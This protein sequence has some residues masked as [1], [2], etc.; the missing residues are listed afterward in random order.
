MT[1]N[2]NLTEQN[3]QLFDRPFFQFSQLKKYDPDSIPQLKTDYKTAWLQWQA[4]ITD[5]YH[6]LLATNSLFSNPHIERWCNGWQVRAHFFAYFKYAKYQE[7][8]PILSILLN[9][10]RLT[11][12]L[13]W[14][15]YKAERSNIPL[16]SYHQWLSHLDQQQ[17]ADFNIWHGDDSEYADYQQLINLSKQDLQP[18]NAQD[19]FIIGKHLDKTEL[20][21]YHCNHWIYQRIIELLPLYEVC[22][23]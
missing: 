11:V 22:F 2:I 14:H 17:Y 4:L 12:S 15:C 6:Q 3:C 21:K 10:R 23:K 16:S 1:T 5:V 13:D 19:F 8:A 7:D 9:R 20:S 18:R